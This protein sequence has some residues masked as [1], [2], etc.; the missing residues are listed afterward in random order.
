MCFKDDSSSLRA[1]LHPHHIRKLRSASTSPLRFVSLLDSRFSTF[2]FGV[3]FSTT[4]ATR[5]RVD[6]NRAASSVSPANP[7]TRHGPG[8]GGTRMEP[9]SLG[10]TLVLVCLGTAANIQATDNLAYPEESY[11]PA[12]NIVVR[13]G[14]LMSMPPLDET[15]ILFRHGRC[16]SNNAF[17][18]IGRGPCWSSARSFFHAAPSFSI[19]PGGRRRTPPLRRQ[20][21]HV[22][23][24]FDAHWPAG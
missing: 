4:S 3:F 10:L 11:R 1:Y 22:E 7:V 5:M 2:P 12:R 8:A 24:T 21:L 20:G 17:F 14:T 19:H 13:A 9:S 23:L 6:W 16:F 18:A 15:K